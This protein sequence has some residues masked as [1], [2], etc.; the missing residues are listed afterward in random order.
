MLSLVLETILPLDLYYQMKEH[1]IKNKFV[2]ECQSAGRSAGS[3]GSVILSWAHIT[4]QVLQCYPTQPG[5]I[6]R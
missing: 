5:L 3:L 1:R 6:N 4:E 2:C